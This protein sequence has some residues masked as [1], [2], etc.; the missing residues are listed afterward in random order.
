MRAPKI[1]EKYTFFSLF[2]VFC[3]KQTA[4][5]KV[6]GN[7]RAEPHRWLMAGYIEEQET[8][9]SIKA[10]A[11]LW[12]KRRWVWCSVAAFCPLIAQLDP[13]ELARSTHGQW[14]GPLVCPPRGASDLSLELIMEPNSC[15]YAPI[16]KNHFTVIF[17]PL[18]AC[19]LHPPPH[20]LC[21]LCP[22]PLLPPQLSHISTLRSCFKL[23]APKNKPLD[24]LLLQIRGLAA[25]KGL[26][27][28]T[29]Q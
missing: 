17:F 21:T 11:R 8:S 10:A 20:W 26:T 5:D 15:C 13:A 9:S 2:C 22:P 18:L 4:H 6:L 7:G 12:W 14:I 23:L 1:E 3:L 27:S 19:A 25:L 24:W 29:K 28:Y 16:N